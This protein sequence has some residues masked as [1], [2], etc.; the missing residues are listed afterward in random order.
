MYM[1]IV[2]C[3]RDTPMRDFP[4]EKFAEFFRGTEESLEQ[5]LNKMKYHID[6]PETVHI[7]IDGGPLEHASTSPLPY[8]KALLTLCRFWSLLPLLTL[9]LK[10]HLE[11]IQR[12]TS[13]SLDLGTLQ[14]AA[15][16]VQQ[17]FN[18]YYTRARD[19][20]GKLH[21]AFVE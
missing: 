12:A 17:V 21:L 14:N 16:S 18:T 19:V 13:K 15:M 7:L 2:T 11:D 8:S 3:F 10:H 20:S 4:E 5:N 6:S 9:M 1:E